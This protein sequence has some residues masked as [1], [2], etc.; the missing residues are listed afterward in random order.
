MLKGSPVI[1]V[2]QFFESGQNN[3]KKTVSVFISQQHIRMHHLYINKNGY[4][5]RYLVLK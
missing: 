2:P 3:I 4:I 5:K 1:T